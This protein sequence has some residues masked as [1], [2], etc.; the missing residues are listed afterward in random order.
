[1]NNSKENMDVENQSNSRRQFIYKAAAGTAVA[2]L[3]S[4]TAW[5]SGGGT[6]CS[7][8]GNLSGNLSQARDC[9]TDSVQGLS[10]TEWATIFSDG[11][12]SSYGVANIQWKAIFGTSRRPLNGIGGNNNNLIKFLPGG[13]HSGKTGND[14]NEA[15]VTAYLNAESGNY[16]LAGGITAYAYVENLYDNISNGTFTQSQIVEAVQDTY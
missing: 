3:A 4:K 2:T 10:P 14:I 12:E 13:K 15:L 9:S 8:S 6:G 7:V 5:A 1:M 11:D 16:P